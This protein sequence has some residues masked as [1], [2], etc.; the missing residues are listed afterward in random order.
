MA[1]IKEKEHKKMKL[2]AIDA[3]LVE[4]KKIDPSFQTI[5]ND[6]ITLEDKTDILSHFPV[7]Q[8][9]GKKLGNFI[10]N[11]KLKHLSLK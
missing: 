5:Y 11:F 8:L 3:V 9:I 4:I 7:L 10:N 1:D 6:G 2:V